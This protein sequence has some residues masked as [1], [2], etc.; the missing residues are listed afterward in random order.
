MKLLMK[1]ENM[2]DITKVL[3]EKAK[4]NGPKIVSVSSTGT[5]GTDTLETKTSSLDIENWLQAKV[6]D[7]LK[8]LSDPFAR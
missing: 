3:I 8:K 4:M 6:D 2:L 5:A 1:E 7:L